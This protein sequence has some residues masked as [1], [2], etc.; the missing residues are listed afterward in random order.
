MRG[1]RRRSR[2]RR[3]KEGGDDTES[4][5]FVFNL[6]VEKKNARGK[7]ERTAGQWKIQR[8]FQQ[9]ALDCNILCLLASTQTR[10]AAKAPLKVELSR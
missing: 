4:K 2:R 6:N 9:Q 5:S 7:E 8:A 3:R 10:Q 1:R